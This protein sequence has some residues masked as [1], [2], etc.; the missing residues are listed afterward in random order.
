MISAEEQRYLYWLG[1]SGWT[2]EGDVV[3]IGPWLGGSTS[4]LASG[5]QASGH[6]A[7]RRLQVFDNF[8][9]REFMATRA[10]LPIRPGDSFET[11]FLENV[12]AYGDIIES[13]V[14]ALPD[15]TIESDDEAAAKFCLGVGALGNIRTTT[16]RAFAED[17]YREIVTSLP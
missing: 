17:E 7:R 11:F 15:E 5:M 4:C 9:W 14:R 10:P 12:S 2:G 6:D 3:E 1:R 13:H 16:L 8:V